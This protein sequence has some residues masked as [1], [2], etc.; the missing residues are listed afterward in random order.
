MKLSFGMVGGGNGAFIGNVHRR[1]ACADEL[2]VLKAGCFTR[3]P[4]KN[5]ETA[6]AWNVSDLSRVYGSYQEMAEAE[7]SREDGIDFVSI[8]T[9]TDTHYEITKCFLNHGIHVVCDKPICINTARS[10]ERRVGKEC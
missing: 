6:A 3:N 9:P 7:S 2:A 4:E 5:R 10:E 8:V 1:G